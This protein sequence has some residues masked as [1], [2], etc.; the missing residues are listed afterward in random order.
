M[1][2]RKDLNPDLTNHAVGALRQSLQQILR[3]G[4]ATCE[5]RRTSSQY[6]TIIMEMS[7]L[8]GELKRCLQ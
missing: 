2:L 8:I 5:D 4:E 1:V 7:S 6:V 3:V